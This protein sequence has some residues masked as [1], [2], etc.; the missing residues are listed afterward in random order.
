MANIANLVDYQASP[1]S[2]FAPLPSGYYTAVIVESEMKDTKKGRGQ[3][4][5]LTHEIIEGE[6]QGKKVW[7]RLNLV[8]DSAT[9]V[10]IANQH[11]AQIRHATGQLQ[12]QDSQQL[13]N[14]PMVIR[15]EF[16]P[17]GPKREREGN[18]IREWK[19]VEGGAQSRPSAP[20][21]VAAPVHPAAGASAAP[22][23]KR[24]A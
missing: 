21:P 7:A 22:P 13:H 19:A 1:E 23:W 18:E 16:Q 11:L 17:A 8:N 20:A 2:Q 5:E 9:A 15:V 10:A 6:S 4:L 14:I 24:T 3:Y 12:V